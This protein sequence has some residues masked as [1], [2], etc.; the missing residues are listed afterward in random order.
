[1]RFFAHTDEEDDELSALVSTAIGMMQGV[2]R[3]LGPTLTTMPATTNADSPRAGPSFEFYRS[4][5]FL[6]HRD[7]AWALFD[8]RFAELA[9]FSGALAARADLP[10]GLDRVHA[11]IESLGAGLRG[12]RRIAVR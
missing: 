2:I 5:E 7:A 11:R 6:P 4:I 3:P 8:E 12:H 10:K 1:M 9:D